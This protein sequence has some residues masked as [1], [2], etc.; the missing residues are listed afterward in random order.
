MLQNMQKK[1][2]AEGEKEKELYEKF[3][4]YC[5][6]AGGD[7]SKSIA[8]ADGK[9][10]ALPSAIEEAEAEKKQLDSSIKKHRAERSAAKAAMAEAEALRNKE[11]VSFDAEKAEASS[12]IEATGKA[13]TAIEKGM[14]GSFLQTGYAQK[15]RQ[16]MLTR[17][18]LDADRQDVMAFLAGGQ[19]EGYAPNSGEIVG[20]LKT[21]KETME[22]ALAEATS[23]EEAAVASFEEL[24]AAKTKEVAAAS[25]AIETKTVRVGEVAVSIVQM[26]NDLSDTEAS[27]AEDK[28]FLADLDNNCADQTKAFEANTQIRSEE[29]V[30]LADTIKILN[31]DDALDLFKKTLPTTSASFIQ[32]TES[33]GSV[34]RQAL[35]VLRHA[36]KS[37]AH[38]PGF[39]FITLAMQGKQMG[40]EKVIKMIDGMV[41]TIKKEQ[42][43]DDNKKEYCGTQFDHADDKKK[44]LTKTVSDLE[45][46]IEQANEGVA[47]LASE[48]EALEDGIKALDKSVAEAT[49]ARKEEHEDFTALMAS[50]SAAK[51]LLKFAMNRLNKFYNPKLYKPPPKRVLSEEDQIVVNMGGTLAPTAAPGG[52]SGT[53]ITVFAQANGAPPPPPE[54]VG[55]YK[56][57]G[58]ESGGVIAMINLLIKD[59]D[60]EMDE[61]KV[62]EKDAQ[63][64]YEQMLNDSAE[65]RALDSKALTEKNEA[66]AGLQADAAEHTDAHGAAVNELM[67]TEKYISSLHAECDWLLQYFDART[68][69]RNTEI[70]SLT[71]A[72]AILSGADYS[73]LQNKR[74]P[75]CGSP[76]ARTT[77]KV[78]LTHQTPRRCCHHHP[79]SRLL[80]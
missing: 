32:M 26:K 39:D 18:E 35:E 25:K 15:L 72:K 4:C 31:D 66:K 58:E 69:A 48:I 38:R 51:E 2:A 70:D 55:A 22:K 40:F 62:A 80:R 60:K 56:K 11:S 10:S 1:V 20:I 24:V 14:A 19:G 27:L 63:A 79:N 33:Q 75:N 71:K 44:E 29:Q 21:M 13:V 46:S 64:D 7:L 43:D 37:A 23:A 36:P 28:K 8:E 17:D 6:N 42:V 76:N 41:E 34:E 59:L 65:K 53:G 9:A 30:A 50:D 5:K 61:S 57:K 47:T 54:A 16:L 3:Q 74:H 52:I 78:K 73:L 68:E 67:A 77:V 49:D 12:N 45:R